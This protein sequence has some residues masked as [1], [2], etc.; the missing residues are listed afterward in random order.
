[1]NKKCE[2]IL[3]MMVDIINK[4]GDILLERD[5]GE[6]TL[7]I[8]IENFGHTHVGCRDCDFDHLVDGLYDYLYK[9]DLDGGQ[10]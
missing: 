1:M 9:I 2:S 10:P 7:T 6:N 3:R 5:F 4:K 8:C